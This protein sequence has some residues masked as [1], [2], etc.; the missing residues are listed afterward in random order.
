MKTFINSSP[1]LLILF[2]LL[3]S[4]PF[5]YKLLVSNNNNSI[6]NVKEEINY[7]N[8]KVLYQNPYKFNEEFII[9]IEDTMIDIGDYVTNNK[10]LL[11]I[12]KRKYHNMAI[13]QMITSKDFLI[14]VQINNCYGLLKNDTKMYV[15]NVD[16][17]CVVNQNDIVYSSNLGGTDKLIPI[18]FVEKIIPDPNQIANR[19]I[20]SYYNKEVFPS[21]VSI[22][23]RVK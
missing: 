20:I 2:L 17:H 23:R 18:G 9:A 11:G 12:I 6:N 22:I 10:G 21:K 1:Y 4:K 15:T 7:P 19:Y 13:V 14:Q 8:G 16:Y 3:I 5:F